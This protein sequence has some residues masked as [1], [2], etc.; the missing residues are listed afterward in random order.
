MCALIVTMDTGLS[1][2][3]NSN[4]VTDIK[5]LIGDQ[6]NGKE[7]LK[8]ELVKMIPEETS[9]TVLQVRSLTFFFFELCLIK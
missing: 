6:I 2:D 4:E 5:K 3:Q 7:P 1:A 9:R 8:A